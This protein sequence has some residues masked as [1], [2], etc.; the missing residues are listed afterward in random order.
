MGFQLRRGAKG[1]VASEGQLVEAGE[2]TE[3]PAGQVGE[4]Q[5]EVGRQLSAD[6]SHA[7]EEKGIDALLP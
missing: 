7:E 2:V 5:Q 4:R 3:R 6:R 1:E